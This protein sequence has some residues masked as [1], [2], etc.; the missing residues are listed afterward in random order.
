MVSENTKKQYMRLL[1]RLEKEKV[2]SDKVLDWFERMLVSPTQQKMYLSAVKWKYSEDKKEFPS[3]LQDHLNELYKQQNARD[4]EQ[5]L[6]GG[7]EAKYVPWKD[8]IDLQQRLDEQAK[9]SVKEWREFVVLSLYTLH[10]P[11]RLNYGTMKVVDETAGTGNELVWNNSPVFIFRE[12]KTAKTYGVVEVKLNPAMKRM[13]QQWFVYLV[14]RPTYVLGDWEISPSALSDMLSS[15]VLKHCG[16]KM[17]ASLF[18]HS[19]I[20]DVFPTLK[21]IKQKDEIARQMM[22]DRSR[23]EM[24][25]LPDKFEDDDE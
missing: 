24:Y 12:Y 22:H 16:K 9:T 4:K 21:T 10:P 20:T 6:T 23:Q 14:K 15:V 17:G 11:A 13:I 7:Q 1:A 25:A 8:I 18:R 2:S 3:S 5:K 19:Y